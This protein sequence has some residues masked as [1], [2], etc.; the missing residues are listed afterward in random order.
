MAHWRSKGLTIYLTDKCNLDC[1]YCY[2]GNYKQHARTI[3][4]EFVYSAI[5]YF[6]RDG[7]G[8]CAISKVRFYAL[9]EPT[10]EIEKMKQFHQIALNRNSTLEFELQTNGIFQKESDA[11]WISSNMDMIWVSLD[12]PPD[13]HDS[14]RYFSDHSPSSHIVEKNI[15]RLQNAAN[16]RCKIGI[17]P[18]VTKMALPRLREIVE[19]AVTL[20]VEAVYFHPAIKPQATNKLNSGSVYTYSPM[21]FAKAYVEQILP[22]IE[23]SK[24]FI[25]N[26][27]TVNFD[28][29]T[30]IFCRSCLPSPQLTIDGYISSCDKAPLGADKRFSPLIFGKWNEN[31]GRIELFDDAIETLKSRTINNITECKE[32]EARLHCGGGCM[33]EIN[34]QSGDIFSINHEFCEA[35]RYLFKHISPGT[36]KLYPYCHP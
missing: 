7:L 16:R 12:G 34:L 2:P 9:G 23:D 11:D 1:A 25:G 4:D 6:I 17:R 24:L 15:S 32:C 29:P 28:E 3:S 30:E 10:I 19:Y 5:D 26:F 36:G 18:T 22:I 20:G 14:F 8:S 31:S 13:L 35:L 27:I 33:G 21:E